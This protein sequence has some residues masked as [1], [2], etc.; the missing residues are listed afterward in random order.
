MPS[1]EASKTAQRGKL[2]P[3]GD[4]GLYRSHTAKEG[5][6]GWDPGFRH[7]PVRLVSTEPPAGAG[8]RECVGEGGRGPRPHGAD[9]E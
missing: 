7:H 3:R 1:R 9:S 5:A 4:H 2:R 8:L 6:T